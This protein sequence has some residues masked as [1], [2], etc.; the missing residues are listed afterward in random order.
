M[1]E[2]LPRQ[3][4][5]ASMPK[6]AALGLLGKHTV[7]QGCP[8]RMRYSE[9]TVR[10][11]FNV[12]FYICENLFKILRQIKKLKYYRVSQKIWEFSD[13]FDIVFL[14]NSLI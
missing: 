13:E 10:N 7:I 12:F 1:V 14:N 6:S 9:T 4:E 3:L 5:N 8:L 2:T 11:S